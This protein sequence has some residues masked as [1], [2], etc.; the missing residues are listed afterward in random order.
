MLSNEQTHRLG[1]ESGH[2]QFILVSYL[3]NNLLK[4]SH[5]SS[6]DTSTDLTA[7]DSGRGGSDV[8]MHHSSNAPG[9]GCSLQ[10][11]KSQTSS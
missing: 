3:Q 1:H 4:G 9:N 2:N 6:S 10:S 5:D 11:S 8:E 7:S